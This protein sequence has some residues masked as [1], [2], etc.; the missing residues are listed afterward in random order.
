M[1]GSDGGGD[2]DECGVVGQIVT[3]EKVIKHNVR[4]Y[5]LCSGSDFVPK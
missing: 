3:I 2:D 4:V 5:T 1:W